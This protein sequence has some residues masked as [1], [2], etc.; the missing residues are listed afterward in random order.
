MPSAFIVDFSGWDRKGTLG[1][2]G[3]T[4]IRE[5]AEKSYEKKK[6]DDAILP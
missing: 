5:S 3:L 4:V 2:K 6:K 1:R